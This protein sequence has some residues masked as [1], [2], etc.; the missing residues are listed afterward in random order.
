[1]SITLESARA[2]NA[3]YAPILR[4]VAVFF[5]GTSGIGQATATALAR[6]TNN[7]PSRRN[8][9][10][11]SCH[12]ECDGTLMRNVQNTA[13]QL[14]RTLPKVNYL[15]ATAGY[16]TLEGHNETLEGLDR[17]LALKFEQLR[18]LE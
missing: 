12:V 18:A 7:S 10:T 14:L 6:Y 1:M 13:T 11:N 9:S 16:L 3:K 15:F 8:L 4:P 2:A 5:G 17:K